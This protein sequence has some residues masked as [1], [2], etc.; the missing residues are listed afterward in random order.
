MKFLVLSMII[1][2]VVGCQKDEEISKA[3]ILWGQWGVEE[4][5]TIYF[6][7]TGMTLSKTTQTFEI[8]FDHSG[9]G[10]IL[11]SPYVKFLWAVQ[12][13]PNRLIIS[14]EVAN[15]N[16]TILYDTDLFII[17]GFSD[18]EVE[19]HNE[20]LTRNDSL[21]ITTERNWVMTVK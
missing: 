3:R 21:D 9:D 2:S 5:K 17:G 16:G 4:T 13:D 20:Y 8:Q 10:F 6:N 12:D 7:P 11:S 1:I 14:K 19:L 15:L 18:E